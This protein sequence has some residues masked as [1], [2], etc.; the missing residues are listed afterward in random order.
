MSRRFAMGLGLAMALLIGSGCASPEDAVLHTWDAYQ[1]ALRAN[2]VPAVSAVLAAGREE[3]LANPEAAAALELRSALAPTHPVVT[4]IEVSALRAVLSVAGEVDGQN[5]TGRISFTK[6]GDVW[7]VFEEEWNVDLTAV[8]PVPNV[9]LAQV[10]SAGPEATPQV[11]AAVVAHQGSVTALE[12]T[13]DG[14]HLVSIGYDDYRLC[15][16]DAVTGELLDGVDYEDRPCDLALLPDGRAA[17]VVDAD[18]G[19]TEWPIEGEAFGGPRLLSGRAGR[20]PRIAVDAGG[21]RAVTT[22]WDDPAKLWDLD[23]RTFVQALPQSEKM[24]GVAFSPVGPT[25]ACGHHGDYFAVWNLDRLS[26]PV[27]SRKTHRVPNVAAQSDVHSVAFSPDGRRL[28]TGHMDSSLSVWDMEKGRQIHNW[29]VQDSSAMDVTF[30]PCGTVLATA[31]QDGRVHLWETESRRTL[32]RLPAHEGAALAVA[33]N[34]A[35]GVTL[36]TGGEDGVLRIWQ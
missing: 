11:S 7:K 17:Y 5:M 22:S 18:G 8:H 25:V 29:Y 16:W 21:H 36:A 13:R 6:E 28:A 31:Q 26:W 14:R 4:G 12:F 1:Q 32:F 19:V 2:D 15:L 34:P 3:E 10:Y 9:D 35:D 23:A 27:G 20:T 24:R 33:F 30:S